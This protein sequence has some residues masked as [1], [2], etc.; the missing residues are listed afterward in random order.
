MRESPPAA[1]SQRSEA[2]RTAQSMPCPPRSLRPCWTAF[3]ENP[4]SCPDD[5]RNPP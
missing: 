4:A 1:F 3:S 2:Q 5:I